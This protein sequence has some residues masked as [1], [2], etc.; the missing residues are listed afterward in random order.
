MQT[1]QINDSYYAFFLDMKRGETHSMIA[2]GLDK[3]QRHGKRSEA[4]GTGLLFTGSNVAWES[5]MVDA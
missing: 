4:V 3:S 2:L 1:D 5:T